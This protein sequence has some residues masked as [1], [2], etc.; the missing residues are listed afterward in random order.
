MKTEKYMQHRK[1]KV[2]LMILAFFLAACGREPVPEPQSLSASKTQVTFDAAAGEQVVQISANCN[3]VISETWDSGDG[4]W[5]TV[6]PQMGQG[7]GTLTVSVQANAGADRTA[8]I[9]VSSAEK[10][11]H[12][13][14]TQ[15]EKEVLTQS[16]AQVR[17]L[18]KGT[19]VTITEK[20]VV[21]AT[22]ISNFMHTDNG[23][24]NNYTSMKAIVVSD[25]EAGI[26]LYCAE[27]NT[28]FKQGDKVEIQLMGQT[29]SVYNN[30]P[31]QVNGIPLSNI[32]KVGTETVT[33]REI[34][35][36]QLLTGDYESMYV[37]IPSVQVMD[38]DLNKTF[39]VGSAH[40]S[41]GMIARSEET[42]DV[43][44]SKYSSFKDVTVPSGSGVLKGIAGVYDGR[45]QISF[46]RVSDWEGLTGD[47]FYTTPTFSLYTTEKEVSGEAGQ[48]TVSIAG[49][50]DW[51]VSSG[52]PEGF[53]VSP[54]SGSGS[55][56]VTVTYTQNPSVSEPRSADIVFTTTD[57]A[58]ATQTL[59]LHVTQSP[60]EALVSDPVKSWMELPKVQPEDAFAY[61]SHMT[62]LRGKSVRNY[63]FWYDTQNRLALWVAYPLYTDIIGSGSRTD[64]WDYNP[65]VPKRYQPALFYSFGGS[66][67]DRGHQL[68]S[69]DRLFSQDVNASTF[70]FTN[71]TAQDPSLNQNLWAGLE[72]KVRDW[73]REC[74]TLYVVTGAMIRTPEDQTV[75]YISDNDGNQVA[76]PRI[77][78]KVL[79]Q[80]KAG[81]AENNGYSAIGFWYEN[82]SYTAENP[83]AADAKN[84]KEIE[85]LTGFDFFHNLPDNI[86]EIVEASCTPEDWGLN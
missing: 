52:D 27:N 17:D 43:F 54:S 60:Y 33:A 15:K 45:Y 22:V 44:S 50:V 74:D 73:A 79:L 80:Y 13:T 49:N 61:I 51:T 3:W 4:K 62:S 5:F 21:E 46:A 53:T 58:I 63:S 2:V 23:G 68:P 7:N 8:G 9:T 81:Q 77:Y 34:S 72:I 37:A 47:R 38:E 6:T 69:A 16:V 36:A 85:A 64:A 48:F 12:I 70:Y 86:E 78:Y 82:R 66:S 31:L 67:Y 10:N 41:I 29:L 84:I 30:G 65:K 40:T 28:T 32:T 56:P 35:A 19:D 55:S 75:E 76:V 11:V 83:V 1:V 14:V 24:L 42:F 18:Y 57:E 26:Q 39:V 59:T 20:I 25:G 71:L